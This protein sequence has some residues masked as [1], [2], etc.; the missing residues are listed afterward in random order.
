VVGTVSLG[1]QIMRARRADRPGITVKI[2]N[3]MHGYTGTPIWTVSIKAINMGERPVG[4]NGAGLDLQDGSG[5][6]F[7]LGRP[8]PIDTIPGTV[9]PRHDLTAFIP[10]AVL[11]SNGFDLTQPL[12][13]YV[14]LATGDT[15]RSEPT[16]LRS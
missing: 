2:A 6:A 16:T 5:R 14:N 15:V 13:G 11:E 3:A 10:V 4:V 7:V 12:V 1:W 9:E 8:E